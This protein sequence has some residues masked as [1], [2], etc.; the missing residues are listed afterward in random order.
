MNPSAHLSSKPKNHDNVQLSSF[1][2]VI[3]LGRGGFGK[4][5]LGILRETGKKYAIKAIRKDFLIRQN[6]VEKAAIE[7]DILLMNN[8]PFLCGMDYLF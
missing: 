1:D 4:V 8:H 2:L 6:M 7:R 5:Y 3:Q